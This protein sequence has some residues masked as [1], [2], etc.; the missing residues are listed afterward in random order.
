MT[1]EFGT[2]LENVI[3]DEHTPHVHLDDDSVTENTRGSYPLTRWAMSRTA[4]WPHTRR[5]SSS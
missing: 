4:K 5:M 1:H 2:I 3:F